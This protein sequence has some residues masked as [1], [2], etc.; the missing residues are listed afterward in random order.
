M[1]YIVPVNAGRLDID[2]TY[3]QEGIQTSASECYVM[4]REGAEVRAS[5]QE[6]TEE[7]FNSVKESLSS[8]P[9]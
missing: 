3:L 4:L 2:Y 6:I 9:A 7:E 1:Y 5:W 8:P